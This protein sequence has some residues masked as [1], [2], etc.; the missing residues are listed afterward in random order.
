[1]SNIDEW[2]HNANECISIVQK[3]EKGDVDCE[4]HPTFT[5]S[6]FG[7]SEVLYGY[8]NLN[9]EIQYI[10]PSMKPQLKVTCSDRLA[11]ES[12][13]EPTN[14]DKTLSKYLR[15]DRVPESLEPVDVRNIPV[16]ETY[17]FDERKFCILKSKP[18]DL[19]A[20]MQY[21]QI[22]SLFFIEGGSFIDI[23]DPKW[24]IYLLYEI[25][26]EQ[27][28]LRGYCT[29]YHYYKWDKTRTDGERPRISQF[30]IFPP[31]QREGHG[32]R[33]YNTIVNIFLED[34]K[35]LEFAVEDSSEAFDD[36]RDRC[37]FQRLKSMNIFTSPEFRLP[38]SKEWLHSQRS[39]TKLPPRQFL[40]CCEIALTMKMKDL[41]L[42]ER[43]ALRLLIK[44]RIFRQNLDVL[45]QLDRSDRLDKIQG[46]YQN[47]LDEYKKIAKKLP[48]LL[49]EGSRKRQKTK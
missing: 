7:D 11:P 23:F 24:T 47:Q 17:S 9:I 49:K 34:P 33:L 30:V 38:L 41:S 21:L 14:V 18:S 20:I 44:E 29:V 36:L 45:L 2:V 39:A 48:K 19:A 31:F 6:I 1:M 27:Y 37:D 32:S 43:K 35:I 15:D 46:A 28:C 10:S 22:F 4:F 8:K 16:A 40:R 12:G 13:V 3:N 42:L 25:K 5:Y 26:E